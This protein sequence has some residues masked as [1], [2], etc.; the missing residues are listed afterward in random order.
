[1][2]G[3][4][5]KNVNLDFTFFEAVEDPI[6]PSRGCF[7]S[8]AEI[9]RDAH[10]RGVNRLGV[11]E[12]DVVIKTIPSQDQLTQI[13]NFLDTNR[14]WEI[15]FLGGWPDIISPKLVAAGSN[16]WRGKITGSLRVYTE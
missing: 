10:G 15:F 13:Q 12:D 9:I 11:F 4:M 2:F 5:A 6:L 14:E 7:R 1:M 16:I 8:H 3:R